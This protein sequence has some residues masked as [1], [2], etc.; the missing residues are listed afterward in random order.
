[1]PDLLAVLRASQTITQKIE[2]KPLVITLLNVMLEQFAARLALLLRRRDGH[3]LVEAEGVA[4]RGARLLGLR[5]EDYP[6]PLPV[7][8]LAEAEAVRRWLSLERGADPG[9]TPYP[10]QTAPPGEAVCLPLPAGEQV[11][12]WLYL[13]LETL[14]E[15]QRAALEL[16]AQSAGGALKNAAAH[17]ALAASE[18]RYREIVETQTELIYRFL[19]GGKLTFVNEAFCRFF[20]I[21]RQAALATGLLPFVHPDDVEKVAGYLGSLREDSPANTIEHR[22]KLAKG[23][24]RWLHWHNRAVFDGQGKIIEFQGVGRDVS[25]LKKMEQS[26]HESDD[27]LQRLIDLSFDAVVIYVD[28]QLAFVSPSAAKL[29]GSDD[30]QALRGR[31]V[32]DFIPPDDLAGVKQR[33]VELEQAKTSVS[34]REQ[35]LIR[36]DGQEVMVEIAAVPITYNGQP[37]VQAVIRDITERKRAEE[38]LWKTAQRFSSLIENGND[39]IAQLDQAQVFRY[40]SQTSLR[41]LGYKSRDLIGKTIFEMVH[42][43]DVACLSERLELAQNR[44]GERV[45]LEYRFRHYDGSWRT[46]EGTAQ[47]LFNDKII[48]GI[49]VN[50]RDITQRKAVEAEREKLLVEE[51]RQRILAQT[52]GEVFLALTAQTRPEAVLDEIL[53]QA[54]RVVSYTAADIALLEGETLIVARGHGYERF[55]PRD[56][57]ADFKQSLTKFRL[58]ASLI[59]T[60]QPLLIIDTRTTPGWVTVPETGWIRSMVAVPICLDDQVLG[61]LRLVSETPADFSEEDMQRL[62]PLA[63]AAA[64]ALNNARLIAQVR[65]ELT[66]RQQAE[67]KALEMNRKLLA[68]QHAGATIAFSLDIQHILQTVTIEMI[69]LIDASGCII[70]AWDQD[71]GTASAVASY[72]LPKGREVKLEPFSIDDSPLI[73]QVL[74][75]RRSQQLDVGQTETIDPA[76]AEFLKRLGAK[77]VL[78][79]PMEYHDYVSG[80]VEVIDEKAQYEFSYEEMALAQFLANQAAGA[81]ETARLYD[82]ARQELEERR[83]A[84]AAFKASEENLRAIFDNSLQAFVLIDRQQ[85]IRALNRAARVGIKLL[86]DQTVK[87]GMS[88]FEFVPEPELGRTRYFVDLVLNGSKPIAFERKLL[89]NRRDH[90][91]EFHYDPVYAEDEQVIGVCFSTVDISE[92]KKKEAEIAA[93]EARLWSEMQALLGVTRALV[94]RPKLPDLLEFIVSEAQRM[95]MAEGARVL[96]L[97]QDGDTLEAA[98]PGEVSPPPSVSQSLLAPMSLIKRALL[99]R[100]LQSSESATPDNLALYEFLQLP[101]T[102]RVLCSP[103]IIHGKRLGVLLVWRGNQPFSDSDQ[104]VIGVFGDQVAL[105]LENAYLHEYN[106]NLAIEQE[107]HRLARNLHDSVTQT[108]YSIGLAADASLRLMSRNPVVDN[109]QILANIDHV[110]S[111]S[112]TALGEMREHLY[113][114]HP[115]VLEKENLV[116]A[117]EQHCHRLRELY[118]IGVE[119]ASNLSQPLTIKQQDGLYFIARE[120]LWNSIK[121]ASAS[122]IDLALLEENDLVTLEIQDNGVGFNIADKLHGQTIG[123]RTMHERTKLLRGQIILES[124]AGRGTHITVQISIETNER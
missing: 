55:G 58:E 62:Q 54:R 110:H 52:L 122:K 22:V 61:L 96:L 76:Q 69:N 82:K 83:R 95:T 104:R 1:M 86:M 114:L 73:K 46:M 68:L 88:L 107:R 23:E 111:L 16:L 26:L 21:S 33:L 80:L 7:N 37:A 71:S 3:W 49:I 25:L 87:E 108:L 2:F 90:W 59:E 13:E 43:A 102:T 75:S 67:A 124:E 35:R 72:G 38:D 109:E 28:S 36:L 121:Y 17:A 14:D 91:F 123:L 101:L 40:I 5:V 79:L 77:T 60:K 65:Q 92:R 8:A 70:F 42:P 117:L 118:D 30:P 50:T 78:M 18:A 24:V 20:G 113:H 105:G 112:K 31:P 116:N 34:L 27:R 106:R 39:V 4:G 57:V 12:G 45:P 89:L 103:L 119:F 44:A 63:D 29:Y 15:E 11:E 48:Q 120:A 51:Q 9:P 64:I 85:R 115:T 47:N 53:F 84:E 41:I 97:S 99:L 74:F 66:E 19:P 10:G 98:R 6:L 93:S 56:P 32:L 81:I 94:S 100:K